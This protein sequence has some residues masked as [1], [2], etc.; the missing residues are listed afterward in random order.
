MKIDPTLLVATTANA[1]LLLAL[2][3]RSFFLVRRDRASQRERLLWYGRSQVL[4]ALA[5][6]K[7]LPE[8][9]QGIVRYLE[10]ASP[11]FAGSILLLDANKRLRLGIATGLPDFLKEALDGLEAKAPSL[12]CGRA[13]H[14]GNPVLVADIQNHPDWLALR[15]RLAATPWRA[16]WSVPILARGGEVL[17]TVARYVCQ[18][19]E[20]TAEELELLRS[21]ADLASLAIEHARSEERLRDSEAH[22][23]EAQRIAHLGSWR[24]DLQSGGVAWSDEMHR[25]FGW[26]AGRPITH[27][28]FKRLIHPDDLAR[29]L[30]EQN[31]AKEDRA[32]L[33]TEYRIV[34]PD[35]EIRHVRERCTFGNDG[36]GHPSWVEGVVLDITDQKRMESERL[37]L[38]RHLQQTQRLE[39]LGILAGGIAHDF[40]N[41]LMAIIGNAELARHELPM[42]SP[43]RG[44]VEKIEKTAWRAADL[45]QQM[46]AYSGR[47]RF[48][49]T[50]TDLN[51]IVGEV[52]P[53]LKGVV[54]ES[55]EFQFNGAEG[56]PHFTADAAQVRQIIISL[57]TN[58]A[59]AL[60]GKPGWIRLATGVRRCDES[61]WED[62][63]EIVRAS[64]DRPLTLGDY[65]FLEVT[66]NGC[67]M[68]LETQKKMF[69]P[70]F[71]T[72]FA[73]RGLSL[74]AVLG[75][76]RGH[77]GAIKVR[78]EPGQGTSIHVFF[79]VVSVVPTAA[80]SAPSPKLV[81]AGS[82]SRP[83][84]LLVDD[85]EPVRV[86]CQRL[87]E[88]LGCQVA[89]AVDGTEAIDIFR[90][91]AGK[92][93]GVLLDLTMP[94]LTGDQ[95]FLKL[96]E[97]NP[98]IKVILYSGYNEQEAAER[99]AGLGIGGFLQKPFSLTALKEKLQSIQ[100]L[101]PNA[102]SQLSAAR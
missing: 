65:V 95:V 30:E 53:L 92:F 83:A 66:D 20:P 31:S 24:G 32:S 69:D 64:Q 71:S 99:F 102:A 39:S 15:P 33:D 61:F 35:G 3:A 72:K 36:K 74:S 37:K 87:L 51:T 84:I 19:R 42:N 78:S 70:F 23:A 13:A 56:L 63:P 25:I 67:G 52:R 45:S 8:V 11:R 91:E 97:I 81:S 90:R 49:G 55:V 22:L 6:Y 47:G 58:A 94:R 98:D 62:V 101:E 43:T 16:C 34:R 93:A 38:E 18:A 80:P 29:L 76:V 14:S 21:A 48:M 1:I 60:S 17:G 2:A 10:M 12:N 40:N 100:C 68:S 85:E 77:R 96:R 57:V 26:P 46:L 88:H 5:R 86:V 44:C 82:P 7:E 73:G 9:L 28:D 41:L 27:E 4:E 79:P 54:A 89:L 50:L 75:M 59:E